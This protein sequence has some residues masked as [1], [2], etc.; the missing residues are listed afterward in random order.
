M[1][2]PQ[3]VTALIRKRAEIAGLIEHHQTMLR[4][5]IID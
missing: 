1:A 3:V 4:Q 2:E 5:A